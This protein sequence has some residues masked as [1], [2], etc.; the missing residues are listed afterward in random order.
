MTEVSSYYAPAMHRWFVHIIF[1][2]H[3]NSK[4][5]CLCL[6][7]EETEAKRGDEF[8]KTAQLAKWESLN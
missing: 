1:S 7:D 2:S 3:N 4:S 6:S 5:Y 8:S